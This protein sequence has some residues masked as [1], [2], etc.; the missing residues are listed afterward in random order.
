MAHEV[1]VLC[2]QSRPEIGENPQCEQ[3]P[4]TFGKRLRDLTDEN[5]R[6]RAAGCFFDNGTPIC[7][8]FFLSRMGDCVGQL[9]HLILQ[10]TQSCA[11]LVKQL[12]IGPRA[13]GKSPVDLLV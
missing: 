8:H 12:G 7:D 9:S 11:D 2:S 13:I 3:C 4:T 5:Y 1:R 6:D 10:G